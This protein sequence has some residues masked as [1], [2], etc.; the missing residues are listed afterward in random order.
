MNNIKFPKYPKIRRLGHDETKGILDG[1]ITIEEKLDGSNFRWMLN[2]DKWWFGSRN[3]RLGNENNKI[4]GMFEKAVNYIKT[5]QKDTMKDIIKTY[6]NLV[7]YG[8]NMVPHTIKDYYWDRMPPVVGFDIFSIKDDRFFDNKTKR[9][10]FDKLGVDVVPLIYEGGA[11]GADDY[12]TI[13]KSAWRD[14]NAEGI[15]IKN[16]K[17]QMFAKVVDVRF[18]EENR[19]V[20]GSYK[21]GDPI[22]DKYATNYRIEKI[23]LKL[24]DEGHP[25]DMTMMKVLPKAVYQDILEE[26]GNDILWSNWI[27]DFKRSRKKIAQKCVKILERMVMQHATT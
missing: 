20:F 3:T 25:L 22:T 2:D 12:I 16:Y 26:H 21:I 6:G 1:T 11:D 10:I 23:I 5:L 24:R 4:G 8:E 13:P 15:V 9:E 18:T 14:G 7:M 17:M 19:K 27:V